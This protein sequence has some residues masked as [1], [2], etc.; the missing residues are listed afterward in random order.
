MR[1]FLIFFVFALGIGGYVGYKMWTKPHR[2]MTT[3]ESSEIL[4][5]TALVAAYNTDEAAA[6]KRFLN[7]AISITGNIAEVNSNE[8]GEVS[9]LLD[10]GDGRVTCVMDSAKSPNANKLKEGAVVKVQGICTGKLLEVILT[11]CVVK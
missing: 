1:K 4:T 9:I 3:E 6:D 11:R 10:G 2:D 8:A 5:A 7:Q